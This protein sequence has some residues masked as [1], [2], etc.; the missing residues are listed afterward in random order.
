MIMEV[1]QKT[2]NTHGGMETTCLMVKIAYITSLKG[3]FMFSV[4]WEAW[5]L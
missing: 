1:E 3:Y 2:T 5:S 4:I